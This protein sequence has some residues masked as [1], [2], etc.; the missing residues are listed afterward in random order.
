MRHGEVKLYSDDGGANP[1]STF[2]TLAALRSFTSYTYL[3]DYIIMAALS[4]SGAGTEIN[5]LIAYQGKFS[6]KSVLV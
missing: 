2:T 4:D 1:V 3:K 6:S 5:V